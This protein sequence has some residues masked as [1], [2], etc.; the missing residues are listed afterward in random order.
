M[1][2]K[3]NTLKAGLCFNLK[4]SQ[5]RGDSDEEYDSIETIVFLEE[6]L[7]G[8]GFEVKRY[9][10]DEALLEKLSKDRPDYVFNITEGKG[11]SRSRESQVPCILDWLGIP[12]YGSDA[13]SLAITL[14]KFLA[15][16]YLKNAGIAV[17]RMFSVSDPVK[18]SALADVFDGR[19]Y[20]VKPR[21]EGSS[22]GIFND[23]VIEDMSGCMKLVERTTI[24]YRQP[25]VIEEFLPK[26]EV[27]AAVIGNKQPI[28]LGMMCISQKNPTQRFVYSIENKRAWKQSIEYKAAKD[29]LPKK[30]I[31]QIESAALSAFKALELRDAA[32]FDFRL[33]D[34]GTARII[35][36]NP[37]PGLSPEYSDM[38]IISKLHGMKFSEVVKT[39]IEFSL[40]RNNLLPA[41]VC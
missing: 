18:V 17:P 6:Q 38:M 37:L 40:T 24:N 19:P 11:Q 16:V 31:D 7:A 36:I 27:T 1:T 41:G 9:E 3:K 8:F 32:R 10:Q 39:I 20:I 33:D 25:A 2:I 14:D 30:T 29:V 26:D 5:N 34:Q 4:N 12:Y 15:N 13:V 23:S 21:W 28:I 22:K 35:D